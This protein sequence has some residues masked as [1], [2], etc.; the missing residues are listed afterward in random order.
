MAV[1]ITTATAVPN[2]FGVGK[3]G[4][5]ETPPTKTDLNGLWFNHIQEEICRAIEDQGYA[6]DALDYGQLS[7]ALNSWQFSG[8]V[9][10]KNGATLAIQSGGIQNVESGGALVVKNGST[11][12]FE[13]NVTFIINNNTV[14]FG[15]S[16]A[17][18]F[19]ANGNTTFG[20]DGTNLH[21]VKSPAQF[22][23]TLLV[24]GNLTLNGTKTSIGANEI[25]GIAGSVVDVETVEATELR[26]DD[27]G[28]TLPSAAGRL[29]FNGTHWSFMDNAGSR[30]ALVETLRGYDETFATVLAL[31]DTT[32]TVGRR[33][34][35]NEPVWIE[36]SCRYEGNDVGDINYRVDV[37]GPL[38]TAT[39]LDDTAEIG[40]AN[41]GYFLH[42]EFPWT[43]TN[44]FGA[45]TDPQ[46]YSFLVRLGITGGG[47]DTLTASRVSIKVSSGVQV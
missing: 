18:V 13:T 38:G 2:L 37:T 20:T 5:N 35:H 4:F 33:I 30:R 27:S 16:N 45:E 23:S 15:T 40:T 12:A 19:A 6:L 3:P 43:P 17:N 8:D 31:V 1:R 29:R 32:A 22:D 42:E 28:T 47:A 26:F 46:N 36:V 41:K 9:K 21:R 10:I 25:E 24:T 44:D 7:T 34:K 14:T 11:I 39:I